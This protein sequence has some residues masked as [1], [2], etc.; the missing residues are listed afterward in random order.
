M[1]KI[2]PKHF[3]IA[4]SLIAGLYADTARAQWVKKKDNG[5]FNAGRWAGMSFTVGNKVYISCGYAG[6][7]KYE[8]DLQEYDPASDSWMYKAAP[9]QPPYNRS[10]GVAFSINGKGYMGLGAEKFLSINFDQKN[11]T[12]M[13]EYDPTTD[14]WK[15]KASLMDSGRVEAGVLVINN[16]AYIIG[17]TIKGSSGEAISQVWEFDP[18]ANKW[19]KKADFPTKINEAYC[20]SIGSKGYVMGGLVGNTYTTKT[21]E[22]DP[23]ADKWTAKADF[24]D[25]ARYGGVAFT[26]NGKGI[27]GLGAN[28]AGNYVG[29]F[30]SYDP[31]KDQWSYIPA[32]WS[33]NGRKYGMAGV[34]GGKAYVGGGWR[35][36]GSVQT[37]FRDWHEADIASAL[38]I[39]DAATNQVKFD[40]YPNPASNTVTVN[41]PGN[42]NTYNYKVSNIMGQ[43]M[44][45]GALSADRQV[46][47]EALA[48]G[49]YVLELSNANESGRTLITIAK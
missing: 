35:M 30:Y 23:A 33:V 31:G 34:I 40:V 19:T 43:S 24:I 15:Q 11:M 14:K 21:Y 17:G 25:T 47:V 4:L 22:Y 5:Q 16:K 10:A 41:L 44:L 37:F 36:D 29:T 7:T 8:Y 18:A 1:R 6:G 45:S 48:A 32:K 12:D 3:A 26:V 42:A 2:T 9:P 49:Q 13:W 46:N 27:V 28:S 38:G 39:D 20:F